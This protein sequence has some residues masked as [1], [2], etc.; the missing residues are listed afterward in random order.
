MDAIEPSPSASTERDHV[1]LASGRQHGGVG[2]VAQRD[3]SAWDARQRVDLREHA[4]EQLHLTLGEHHR[5]G[6]T[7]GHSP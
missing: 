4:A 3:A 5:R 6:V 1:D 2:R 7:L